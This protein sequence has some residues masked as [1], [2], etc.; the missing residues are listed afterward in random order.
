[1]EQFHPLRLDLGKAEGFR[2]V[3]EVLGKI[4]II[5]HNAGIIPPPEKEEYDVED[6]YFRVNFLG[7]L[8]L[9]KLAADRQIKQFIFISSTAVADQ[10]CLPVDEESSYHPANSYYSSKIAAEIICR[11]YNIEEKVRTAVLRI[12]A[13]YGYR[14]INRAVIPRFI[15]L[16]RDSKDLTLWGSGGRRQIFTFVEDIGLACELAILK[17]AEGIFNITGP[18]ST[19]MKELAELVLT[20]YSSSGS[21][22]VFNGNFDPQEGNKVDISIEKAKRQLG[23]SPQF[24]IEAGLR[25]IKKVGEVAATA[26]FEGQQ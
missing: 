6:D 17:G 2:E 16:A 7:T 18:G 4:D 20:V 26:L 25:K 8:K 22:I 19:T 15:A 14:G 12:R 11:Q 9:L 3:E 5:I 24:S 1:M 10:A 21:K 23:Y 13:P